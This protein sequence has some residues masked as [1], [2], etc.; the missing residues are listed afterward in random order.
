MSNNGIAT[1]GIYSVHDISGQIG[2]MFG[3]V[4]E[5]HTFWAED[6]ICQDYTVNMHNRIEIIALRTN[7]MFFLTLSSMGKVL[8]RLIVICF[9][10]G[11]VSLKNSLGQDGR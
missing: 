5:D 6:N 10:I 3:C 9:Y 7:T 2:Q 8:M 11:Q 4:N 1:A